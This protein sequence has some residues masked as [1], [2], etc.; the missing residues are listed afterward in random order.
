M[1]FG[2]WNDFGKLREVA[3]GTTEGIEILD[4]NETY[5]PAAREIARVYAGRMANDIP[6]VAETLRE[7]QEQLDNLARIY[8]EHGVIVHRPRPHTKAEY[9]YDRQ[10]QAGTHQVFPADPIWIIGRYVVECRFKSPFR[11][12]GVFPLRELITPHV[13]ANPDMR[14]IACPATAPVYFS[15]PDANDPSRDVDN[16]YLEGGDILICGNE[17]RDILVGVDERR[18]SSARGVAWLGTMLSQDGYRV[19]PVPITQ[20]APIHLLGA[21]GACGPELA[22]AYLPSFINGLPAPI[23]DW[24]IIECTEEEVRAGGPCLVMLER[25]TAIVAAETPR[26]IGEL[27][28]RGIKVIP[29]PFDKVTR[30]DGA[31]RC[32]TFVMHREQA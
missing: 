31:I 22:I 25:K 5:P 1:S 7:T 8:A 9:A 16:Y 29:I 21:I 2:V 3:V 15:G 6:E 10:Y 17:G 24:D 11:N 30:F 4:D 12:K 23:K 26:L 20:D 28:N 19:T 27:E 18:S 13:R 14:V 32:A